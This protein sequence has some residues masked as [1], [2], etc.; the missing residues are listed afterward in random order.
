MN[1]FFGPVASAAYAIADQLPLYLTQITNGVAMS[2]NPALT[3]AYARKRDPQVQRM[4]MLGCIAPATLIS[5]V[6]VPFMLDARAILIFWLGEIPDGAVTLTR[7][8]ATMR[9][10]AC[11]SEGHGILS[12]AIGRIAWL[13]VITALP[14][15]IAVGA[16]CVAYS[17]FDLPMWLNA[18]AMLLAMCWVALV[19]RPLHVAKLSGIGIQPWIRETIL[20][21]VLVLAPGLLIGA[22][23]AAVVPAGIGRFLLCGLLCGP[24]MLAVAYRFALTAQERGQAAEMLGHLRTSRLRPRKRANVAVPD[25]TEEHPRGAA[26]PVGSADAPL[27]PPPGGS[28]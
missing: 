28:A 6:W 4:L 20:P 24:V 12:R 15:F 17:Y 13:Q 5:V 8:L 1:V 23:L 16:V 11:L 26:V 7:L 2:I 25:L 22:L 9:L 3:T 18:A 19:H 10:V 21:F 14:F 27:L